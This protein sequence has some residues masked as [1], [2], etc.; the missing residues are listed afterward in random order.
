[1]IRLQTQ[2]NKRLNSQEYFLCF[3]GHNGQALV[4]AIAIM[5]ILSLLGMVGVSLLGTKTGQSTTGFVQ[6][7]Q[8][9][10]LAH[11]G[12]E[13]YMQQL[14]D[15]TDWTNEVGQSKVFGLGSFDIDVSNVGPTKL[16]IKVTGR[17]AG[18]YG[19]ENKSYISITAKKLPKASQFAVFWGRNTGSLRA[20]NTTNV[21]GDVWSAGSMQI[22][23]GNSFLDGKVYYNSP[24]D[25]SGNGTYTK[26]LLSG[27]PVAM[28]VISPTYYTGLMDTYDT[29][30]RIGSQATN[31]IT[32]TTN[33]TLNGGT[34]YCRNF[35]TG[36]S[37]TISGR[38]TIVASQR[39]Y[40]HYTEGTSLNVNPSAGNN[41]V[42]LAG[43]GIYVGSSTAT[44]N[45]SSG[46]RMYERCPSNM[47]YWLYFTGQNTFVD[48]A[49]ILARRKIYVGAGADILNSTLFVD[50][51]NDRTDNYIFITGAGT[52]VTGNVIS[53]GRDNNGSSLRIQNSANV[54]G[55][56]YQ[57][58]SQNQGGVQIDGSSSLRG[59]LIANRF[60]RDRLG[61]A[62]ITYS[63]NSI[64]LI[65]PFGFEGYVVA[66]PNSWD[67]L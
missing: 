14:A 42:F 11:A 13:W 2:Q 17:V 43:Q 12:L 45:M 46:V 23:P 32:R 31:D 30:W 59:A 3:C 25:I 21:Y 47:N 40:L 44:I 62:T 5:I 6:S 61:P 22:N 29:I 66:V 64:P 54:E 33:L 39:I 48:S 27:S 50:Y 37:I 34:L 8:A 38:G 51:P 19:Q 7:A 63:E 56:V 9:K 16:D 35:T 1:M 65:P 15:D 28:P 60:Y 20:Q 57:Y 52:R 67:G 41:I 10:Y 18:F 24:N 55:L 49:L 53:T 4:A 58:D 36:G 26:Q